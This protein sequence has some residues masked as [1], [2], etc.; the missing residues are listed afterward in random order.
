MGLGKAP[1]NILL[2]EASRN[3]LRG[4]VLTLGRQD[5]WLTIDKLRSISARSGVPLREIKNIELSHK[6]WFSQQGYISDRS[7]F[8]LLGFEQIESLDY[9]DYEGANHI[10]DLNSDRMPNHLLGAFDFIV[11]GGTLEHVFHVPNVL[12]NIFSMLRTGGRILHMAPS[13]NHIDHGFYMFSPTL[14]SDFY[15]ANKFEINLSQIYR[16]TQE[17]VTDPWEV[18][19]YEPGCLDNVSFGGLDNSIYG[20]VF[21][22]TKTDQSSG[23]AIPQQGLSRKTVTEPARPASGPSAHSLENKARTLVKSIPVA[24]ELWKIAGVVRRWLVHLRKKREA[25]LRVKA[26]Y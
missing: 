5:I 22:A 18:I 19:D 15:F 24:R 8:E 3:P 4:R 11:D 23:D 1:A 6:P 2:Q 13:S 12:K 17:H 25:E 7:F 10:A 21:L 9:S 14:F 16:H 20:I 26:R